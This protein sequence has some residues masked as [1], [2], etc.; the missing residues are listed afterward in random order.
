MAREKNPK[1]KLYLDVGNSRMKWRFFKSQTTHH[2][3]SYS[4]LEK[5]WQEVASEHDI[6]GIEACC[7]RNE[8]AKLSLEELA[9]NIFKANIH[10][11]DAQAEQNGVKNGY[12]VPKTLGADRWAALVGARA[13]QEHSACIVVDAGTAITVDF[14]AAN[15]QHHGGVILPGIWALLKTLDLADLLSSKYLDLNDSLQAL[16]KTTHK[17]LVSGVVFSAQGGVK[18]AIEKQVARAGISMNDLPI[19]LTG[20]DAALLDVQAEKK[21]M[22]PDLVLEGLQAMGE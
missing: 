14:L 20:G 12:D 3:K 17:G 5:A 11:R 21:V 4:S 15:G 16:A 2:N 18:S 9:K 22:T 8:R 7:V 19:F 1:M 6:V 10:W 13:R